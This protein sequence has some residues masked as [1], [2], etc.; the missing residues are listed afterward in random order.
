LASKYWRIA[1][2][3]LA[4]TEGTGEDI[5]NYRDAAAACR[6]R[7]YN[8]EAIDERRSITLTRLNIL[9]L[10]TTTRGGGVAVMLD[11]RT[12]HAHAG[13]PSETHG[14]RLPGD[15][16]RALDQAGIGVDAIDL[17]AVAAGPGSFT[18]LRVGIAAVQGIAIARGLKVVPVPTLEALAAAA[19]APAGARVAAWLDGQRGEVFGAL[20]EVSGRRLTELS[21]AT[22]GTAPSV[23]DAWALRAD[24]SVIFV[25]D[26]AVRYRAAIDQRF[27]P[28]V[29]VRPP[30]PLAAAVAR[31]AFDQ[32][33][34]AVGPHDIVPVYVRRSDA[35]IARDRSR[36]AEKRH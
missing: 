11:G 34:R 13:D 29:Q 18:G 17:L 15:I 24:T 21:P 3:T 10:D 19:E 30:S 4:G 8:I 36:A 28:A 16:I 27:G 23:L 2:V 14:Q 6:C 35:E 33:D 26:G 7:E 22:V 20:Y 32:P 5:R 12:I 9:A 31:I 1:G 25:G